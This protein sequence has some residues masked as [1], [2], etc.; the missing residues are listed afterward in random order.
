MHPALSILTDSSCVLTLYF[1][2]KVPSYPL[3]NLLSRLYPYN[4]L[5]NKEGQQAVNDIYQV[6]GIVCF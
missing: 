2:F 4:L 6:C 5:L 3:S 1:L